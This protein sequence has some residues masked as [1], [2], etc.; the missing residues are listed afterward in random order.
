M[1]RVLTSGFGKGE[2]N[3]YSF[4]NGWKEGALTKDFFFFFF[5]LFVKGYW[6]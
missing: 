6:D 1:E 3:F 5:P 4:L 2:L